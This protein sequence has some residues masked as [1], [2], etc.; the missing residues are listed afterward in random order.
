[1]Y[2]KHAFANACGHI[3]LASYITDIRAST[4]E[5]AQQD[6]YNSVYKPHC[7]RQGRILL[8]N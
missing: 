6:L 2:A 5:S 3:Y 7:V 8:V 1:M 4:Q